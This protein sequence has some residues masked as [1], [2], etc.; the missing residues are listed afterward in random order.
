MK[1]HIKIL[2][3]ISFA[4]FIFIIPA[5]TQQSM[6]VFIGKSYSYRIVQ[7]DKAFIP[8][9]NYTLNN[10]NTFANAFNG[11]IGFRAFSNDHWSFR[12]GLELNTMGFMNEPWTDL[13]WPQEF[14]PEGFVPDPTLPHKIQTGHMFMFLDLP[15]AVSYKYSIGKWAPNIR[16]EIIPEYLIAH[17]YVRNTNLSRDSEPRKIDEYYNRFNL[18]AGFSI[19][20][21]YNINENFSLFVNGY[22][23]NQLLH[24]I[25]NNKATFS[26]YA[27]GFNTGVSFNL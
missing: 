10:N 27:L 18:A 14:T 5:F 11:G 20:T 1:S 16:F 8:T 17:N 2:T 25:N 19:G 6:E 12:L 13:R 4:V 9:Q 3:L 24:I 23:K 15:L 26:L 21:Y 7:Y 22:Y